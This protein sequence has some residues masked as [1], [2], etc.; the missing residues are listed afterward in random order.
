[1]PAVTNVF[2]IA[3]NCISALS[4]SFKGVAGISL[5]TQIVMVSPGA[6]V[7]VVLVVS[8]EFDIGDCF[9]EL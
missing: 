3:D 2:D 4:L 9:I 5:T 7:V 8:S 1:M 6:K